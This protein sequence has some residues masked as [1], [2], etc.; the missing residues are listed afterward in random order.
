VPPHLAILLLI[1]LLFR[2]VVSV[3]GWGGGPGWARLL[4][5]CVWK[6]ETL[7]NQHGS[8]VVVLG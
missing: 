8:P 1:Y 3:V 7:L 5:F 4:Q 2:F 6:S